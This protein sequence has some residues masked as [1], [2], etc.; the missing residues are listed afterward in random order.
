MRYAFL[1]KRTGRNKN[2]SDNRI[3]HVTRCR[4]E[5]AA[6]AT[7]RANAVNVST[8]QTAPPA[9]PKNT[10]SRLTHGKESQCA[11][12]LNDGLPERAGLGEWVTPF[13]DFSVSPEAD[14][15]SEAL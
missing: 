10:K 1:P 12:R 7:Q 8:I 14:F 3:A 2:I 6:T 5:A 11:R 15:S 4:A 13:Y 9:A